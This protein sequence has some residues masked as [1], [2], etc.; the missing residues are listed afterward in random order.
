MRRLLS[1]AA[2]LIVL[3]ASG[4]EAT[5]TGRSDSNVETI[6]V[7]TCGSAQ[8]VGAGSCNA[9]VWDLGGGQ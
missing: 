1:I 9:Q 6:H 4:C 7:S 8:R 5:Y 2:I 3:A